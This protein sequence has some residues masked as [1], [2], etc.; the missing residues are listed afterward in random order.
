MSSTPLSSTL[1]HRGVYRAL[2][3]WYEEAGVDAAVGPLARDYIAEELD[4]CARTIV[5]HAPVCVP[6]PEFR[7]PIQAPLVPPPLPLPSKGSRIGREQAEA[8]HDLNAL[9]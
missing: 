4:R 3:E 7:D 1:Q 2:L 6:V 9:R 8:C 5:P